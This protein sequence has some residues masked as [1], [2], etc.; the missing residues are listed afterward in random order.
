MRKDLLLKDRNGTHTAINRILNA[1]IRLVRQRIH[2]IFTVGRWQLME[3]LGDIR[4]AK[5]LPAF[6]SP[7]F[8]PAYYCNGLPKHLFEYVL[9]CPTDA[10]LHD[11]LSSRFP[12]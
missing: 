3:H 7:L 1:C 2:T 5:H 8:K 11:S 4:D 9:E 6:H 12:N 10:N